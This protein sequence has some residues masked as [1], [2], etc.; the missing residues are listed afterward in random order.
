MKLSILVDS[1]ACTSAIPEGWYQTKPDPLRADDRK[2]FRTASGQ[3]LRAGGRRKITVRLK[4]GKRELNFI[5]MP[6]HKPLCS[7]SQLVDRGHTVVFCPAGSYI[8]ESDGTRHELK[9]QGGIFLLECEVE[10]TRFP[11]RQPQ[12]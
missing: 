3:E 1:G 9:R 12:A 4:E 6:V 7:V 8:E 11:H 5:E 2:T 10:P